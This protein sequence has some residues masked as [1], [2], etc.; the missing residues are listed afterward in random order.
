MHVRLVMMYCVDFWLMVVKKCKIHVEIPK[1]KVWKQTSSKFLISN[2]IPCACGHVYIGQKGRVIQN[3]IRE[4]KRHT[5][6]RLAHTDKSSVA[7]HSISQDHHHH[8][9]HV[10]ERLGLIP[11][12]C[13]LKMKLVPPS[14]S[15]SSYASSS[16][17]FILQCLF[18]YP[19]CVHL[20]YVS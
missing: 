16:F 20:L 2:T 10:Q 15:R 8:H 12:P 5:C 13:I 7:E 17:W 1:E 3:R 9:H 4:H 18:R 14:L 11:V 19:V 6:I